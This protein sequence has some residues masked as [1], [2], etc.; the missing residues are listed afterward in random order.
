[1]YI[2]QPEVLKKAIAT[3]GKEAQTFCF[4]EE[5]GELL[6]ALSKYRRS[7]TPETLDHLH[8]EIADVFI[9]LTQLSMMYDSPAIQ[10]YIDSKVIALETKLSE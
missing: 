9:M 1:M 10:E 2:Q 6:Q 3:W 5:C 7:N 8:E 4:I